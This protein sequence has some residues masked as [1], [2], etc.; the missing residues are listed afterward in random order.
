M[1]TTG[2]PHSSNSMPMSR[3]IQGKAFSWPTAISTSSHSMTHVGLAGRHQVAAA[4]VVALGLRP[5]RTR[6]P[7]SRPS[8]CMNAFGHEEV[9]DRDALVHRIL[10]LPGR[11]LHLLEA[12]AHDDLDLLAAE[13]A[14]GAAAIHGG[15][16]AAE[17]DDAPADL[18]RYG[19]T[20]RSTAS[21]CRYG[22]WRRPPCGRGC[23]GRGR[24]AR[25][26]RRRSAS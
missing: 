22:C 3:S 21:R 23:R 14:R 26:C 1:S 7:V 4:F 10:L 25:R 24:A 5:S 12:G 16:A 17:H 11:R 18:R 13:A 15:V 6:M 9:E 20:R 8:S 2:M 19:R